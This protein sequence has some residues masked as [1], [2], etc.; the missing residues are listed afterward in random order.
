ML[1]ADAEKLAVDLMREFGLINTNPLKMHWRFEFDN[2][3]TRFGACYHSYSDPRIT[4]SRPLV[5]LN[6]QKQVE[7][8][9]RHEIAHALCP[10]KSGH[11]ECWKNMCAVT[12]AKPVRCYNR[13]DVDAPK[14]DWSATCGGC[15]MTH[16]VFRKPK[17]DKWCADRKCV[18][19]HGRRMLPLQRLVWQ[20]KNAIDIVPSEARRNA[21][22]AMKAQLKTAEQE[23]G[24]QIV[25]QCVKCDRKSISF[26]LFCPVCNGDMMPEAKLR[27]EKEALKNRIAELERKAGKQ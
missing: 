15:G 8:T 9:I 12:G 27:A 23:P 17:R 16:Y 5:L 1:L 2:R 7:D 21:I 13:D 25:C 18:A 20:H 11:G 26:H 22:D 24:V 10:V 6:D 14:G 19:K 4:L 3:R